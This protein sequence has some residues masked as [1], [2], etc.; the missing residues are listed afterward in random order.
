MHICMFNDPSLSA[1]TF[2]APTSV[3]LGVNIS[4]DVVLAL[5]AGDYMLW[6][7]RITRNYR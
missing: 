1:R 3:A 7:D 5:I 6:W 2:N 4:L